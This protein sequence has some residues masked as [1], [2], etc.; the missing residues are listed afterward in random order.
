MATTELND[1]S[2]RIA[3][4][5]R[6]A[7]STS[8]EYAADLSRAMRSEIS[9]EEAARTFFESTYKTD[10]MGLV[11]DNVFDRLVNGRASEKPAIYRL[12][13]GFGGGKT[14][15]LITLAAST[16][17]PDLVTE[18]VAPVLPEFTPAG[19][20]R[21]VA[22]EGERS[23]LVTGTPL[24]EYGSVR[25]KSLIGHIA[26]ALGGSDALDD[27][28]EYDESLESPGSELIERLIGDEPCLILVDEM[29][30]Y[31]SKALGSPRY[32]AYARTV[33]P[34]I[35]A[36]ICKAVSNKDR[37]VLVLTTP[38]QSADA[39][40]EETGIL[41]RSFNE[42]QS[43]LS[44]VTHEIAPSTEADLPFIL[45]K[46][47]FTNTY[48]GVQDEVSRLYAEHYDRHKQFIAPP[49]ENLV[50]WFRESYPFHPDTLGILQRQVGANA[51]FQKVRGTIRL[52][53]SALRA[54][55]D[56]SA[57]MLLH[58]HH[59]DFANRV[60]Y[61][62]LIGRLNL[63]EYETPI[64]ADITNANSTAAKVDLTRVRVKPAHRLSR[65]LM[66]ASLAPQVTAKGLTEAEAIRAE[67]T[68]ADTDPTIL[69]N[70]L[71]EL[72]KQALYI[73]DDPAIQQI[74]FDTDPNLNRV[75]AQS[76]EMVSET[77]AVA[78]L[79]EFIGDTFVMESKRS[80]AHLKASIFP[81]GADIPDEADAINLGVLSWEWMHT[82]RDG[83]ADAIAKFFNNSPKDNGN[84]PREYRNNICVL[85]ADADGRDGMLEA[86]K[87]YLGI[88]MVADNPNVQLRDYQKTLL[89]TA[90]ETSQNILRE[91]IQKTYVN[92]YHPSVE[93]RIRPDLN[94]RLSQIQSANATEHVGDGQ[95]AIINQ[96]RTDGKLLMPGSADL[97]PGTFWASR[98]NLQHG[99][100][101]LHSLREQFA[102][103]PSEYKLLNL[104]TA[105]EL[106]RNGLRRDA[107]RIETGAGDV[108]SGN[109]L[110]AGH[111]ADAEAYVY[112]YT[113]A[114]ENCQRH[115][116]DC[117]CD[118]A[119]EPRPG[120]DAELPP[121]IPPVQPV[122]GQ[123]EP[124]VYPPGKKI[125]R[126]DDLELEP[127]SAL[128]SR[129]SSFMQDND[130]THADIE[131]VELSGEGAGFAQ[132]VGSFNSGL[133]AHVSYDLA[134]AISMQVRD[135]PLLDWSK[136][137]RAVEQLL[138]I[139]GVA[140]R[141]MTVAV[142]SDD[143]QAMAQFLG[144]LSAN[145]RGGIQVSF[146]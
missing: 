135:M 63:G 114:C 132:Q 127:F 56:D 11:C 48:E 117:Q 25:A 104:D 54:L 17:H 74:R 90:L 116:D 99:K 55:P 128:S 77:V 6:D 37:A 100:V 1:L 51:N 143:P 4:Q 82:G 23:N 94:V 21:L 59:L 129:L 95:R 84:A 75:I 35:I 5:L 115:Q 78:N 58:P 13:S 131:T 29:V 136:A 44:R 18:G 57:A 9:T 120:A 2:L 81:S 3:C 80:G 107:I 31:I 93:H 118:D 105:I 137:R 50:D 42:V 133:S 102:R 92:L 33:I 53:S 40:Q 121:L 142:N 85:V 112:L 96:L 144:S 103:G 126:S 46:R 26:Y 91:S 30:N 88:K 119:V 20:V 71:A 110:Q 97:N 139:S 64:R 89:K 73:N 45:R 15:T 43:V 87:D 12:G 34:T 123:Q 108:L 140:D 83:L 109:D 67:L 145:E 19:P 124:Q 101:K 111:F 41:L 68:P 8:E 7:E 86:S 27:F 69:S 62:E 39:F 146:K 76:R 98:N 36:D 106:F 32:G 65:A 79:R 60:L 16:L 24:N 113:S 47:L 49:Q 130:L 52:L 61:D 22:F 138:K 141:G 125:F 14:H 72:R 10:A 66:L 134:G 38:E 122:G 28:R 70:G